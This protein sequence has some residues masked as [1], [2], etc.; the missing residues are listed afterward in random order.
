MDVKLVTFIQ[1][2]ILD[3]S[4]ETSDFE[5][6]KRLNC[7]NKNGRTLLEGQKHTEISFKV[8]DSVFY[9][10][11]LLKFIKKVWQFQSWLV[12]KLTI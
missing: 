3:S 7:D 1:G 9:R 4:S 11:V 10:Q 12:R 8:H 2:N 6:P 5:G